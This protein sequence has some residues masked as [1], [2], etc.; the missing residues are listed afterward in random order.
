MDLTHFTFFR[1]SSSMGYFLLTQLLEI[2]LSTRTAVAS[3]GRWGVHDQHGIAKLVQRPLP[4]DV[5]GHSIPTSPPPPLGAC[6]S[7]VRACMQKQSS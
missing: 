2:H 5:D 1:P 7:V 4:A 6:T 3:V